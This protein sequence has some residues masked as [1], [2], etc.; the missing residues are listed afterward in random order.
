MLFKPLFLFALA[1]QSAA[2]QISPKISVCFLFYLK[3][4]NDLEKIV[5][6]EPVPPIA[7]ITGATAGIGKATARLLAQKGW[8]LVLT[9]RREA[10]LHET[11]QEI[12][13]DFGV[14]VLPLCFDVRHLEA[15][16]Y[17]I[18]SLE[19]HWRKIRLLVNNA[20]LAAGLDEFQNADIADWEVMIDTNIKG[21]LYV[22][23]LITPFL[24]EQQGGHIVNVGSIAGKEVYA[25]GHVYCA[26]KFA[27]DALTK[28]MRV[29][30]LKHRIKVSSVSPGAVE[31]EF[32]MVRF[33]GDEA[34]AAKVYENY[35][36]LT[37]QDVAEA[38]AYIALQPYHVY[39]QDVVMTP[40]AQANPYYWAK[41]NEANL[42]K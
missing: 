29:D 39:I 42:S 38:I 11:A 41:D 16:A 10:L 9:G 20:G 37:A 6:A 14:K 31:T 12:Q 36:P 24:I 4:L 25:K 21:L 28:A 17:H 26:T 40:I 23:R 15:V 3:I 22:S 5:K 32:S 19:G 8:D 33:K 34:K 18:G 35:T 2:R 1:P 7:F 30:L 27:V 13:R